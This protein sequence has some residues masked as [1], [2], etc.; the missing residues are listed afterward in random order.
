ML[1]I[2]KCVLPA[3]DSPSKEKN[4]GAQNNFAHNI[5]N[6]E[7]RYGLLA[8]LVMSSQIATRNEELKVRPVKIRKIV[9]KGNCVDCGSTGNAPL[10]ASCRDRRT[11]LAFLEFAP[12]A[13]VSY[14]DKSDPRRF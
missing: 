2:L 5:F 7:L 8:A 14:V 3:A 13:A 11:R 12:K 10:C 9:L 4:W 1:Q 6:D